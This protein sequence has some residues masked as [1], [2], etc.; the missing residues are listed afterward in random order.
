MNKIIIFFHIYYTELIDEYLW[1]INNVKKSNYEFDLYVSICEEVLTEDVKNK[2]LY[3]CSNITI[4]LCENRGADIGGF[5]HTIRKNNINLTNYCSCLYLHTKQSSHIG[6]IYSYQW[7]GQ[8]LNDILISPDL[9]NY[10]SNSIEEGSGIIGSNRCIYKIND[11]LKEY[12]NEKEHYNN[13]CK[14]MKLNKNPTYFV[15]GTIF[16]INIK[17]IEFIINSD[18]KPD[19]FK[20]M[21][22]HSGLLEHGFERIFGNISTELNLPIIGVNLDIDSI[23]YPTNF[24]LYNFTYSNTITYKII[25]KILTPNDNKILKLKKRNTLYK[26]NNKY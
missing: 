10:C 12:T 5:F 24:K 13:L 6:P 20:V 1:Y 15:A 17:I 7:R 3:F 25:K 4:T 11:S 8:L 19:D 16:W 23:F 14:R 21:F 2:L 9:V 22:E 18:I 26:I